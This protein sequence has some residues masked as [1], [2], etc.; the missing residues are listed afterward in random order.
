MRECLRVLKPG[1]W[2]IMQVPIA[3][4]LE[5]TIEDPSVEDPRE[6]ERRFGQDDHIR[7]YTRPDYVARLERAGFQVE[8]FRW[9]ED[10]PH[11]GGAENRYGLLDKEVLFF[12]RKASA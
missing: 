11:Y 10:R 3:A 12:L 9:T 2:A 1:G 7:I 5:T 8:Q 6:R 4:K